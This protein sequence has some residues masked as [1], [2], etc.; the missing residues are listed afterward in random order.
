MKRRLSLLISIVLVMATLVASP[1]LAHDDDDDE[2]GGGTYLALGDSLAA[3]TQQ[4]IPFTDNGYTN[5]LF[6]ELEDEY[7]FDDF[8]NLACPGD[9]SNEMMVG[10]NGPNGG[11]LCYG[12]GNQ[13]PPG[14]SSQL[15]AA[16]A[17]LTANPGKVK[18]ITLTMGANDILACDFTSPS[19][20]PCFG[21]ALGQL[22]FNLSV[23][24]GT[25]RAVAPGVPIVGM[26]YYNANLGLWPVA[27]A[28]A[29]STQA[30]VVPF[31]GTIEAVYG[32]FGVPVADVE[33]AFD[34]FETNGNTPKNFRSICKYTL[35]CEKQG[36]T[37]VL[38]DYDP[39][40]PGPQ[41]DIH[42]TNK[43]YKKI[44]KTFIHLIEDLD[45]FPEGG[46]SDDD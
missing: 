1:A 10:D 14:G 27:P 36:G 18:L 26:N 37:Y 13:L 29:L 20:L 12:T 11:S 34:T 41:T 40:T 30:L 7:G 28:F 19:G 31:N 15:D 5:L 45:L 22:G 25:L 2:G 39:G 16:V 38:S 32:A 35:M 6:D 24:L 9:D 4:P 43:G 42:P 17:Y 33:T 21:A 44:A 23:I 8:V 46:D 3:G